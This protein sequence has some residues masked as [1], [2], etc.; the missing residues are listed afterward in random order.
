M[1]VFVCACVVGTTFI[2]KVR[3]K[4]T[5]KYISVEDRDN[6]NFPISYSILYI[7]HISLSDTHA[8][9][10]A[11]TGTDGLQMCMLFSGGSRA[12]YFVTPWPLYV[13]EPLAFPSALLLWGGKCQAYIRSQKNNWQEVDQPSPNRLEFILAT[14][15]CCA[16]VFAIWAFCPGFSDG[17]KKVYTRIFGRIGERLKWNAQ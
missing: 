9:H 8:L 7:F 13:A 4:N 10:S 14:W 2:L 5:S 1:F 11:H 15:K 16:P 17:V 6:P 3:A 12:T